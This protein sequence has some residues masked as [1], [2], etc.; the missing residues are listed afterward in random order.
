MAARDERPVVI[1]GAG[2]AG[3]SVAWHLRRL[4]EAAVCLVEREAQPGA[5]STGRN[6]A[7]LREHM[8]DPRLAPWALRGAQALR[9]GGLCA[10]RRSGGLLV[11]RGREAVG[12]YHRQARGE[13]RFAA[14]D[15]VV[16]VAGLLAAYLRGARLH[17]GVT[18]RALE[19]EAGGWRVHAD[20]ATLLARAVVNA[21]GPW[22]GELFGLPLTP[23]N[24]HLF[25][26]APDPEID[27]TGP[28]VW[29]LEGG[30]YFRPESGGWLL[31]A[32]DEAAAA[33]GAYAEREE[34]L[35][36]LGAKLARH[37][38]GLGDLRVVRRWVGQR[39]FAPDGLPVLGADP[40][41]PG[42]FHA[43]GLGGH[44]ITWAHAVGEDVAREVLGARVI[45]DFARVDRLL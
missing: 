17:T 44:G 22:A 43:A 27:R 40:R 20:G 35:L 28:F 23:R 13:A 45:P 3:A 33:P 25:V 9:E 8:E 18:V 41:R 21:A 32:C 10:F 14:G 37:Q 39:T 29:D 4:G 11:G 42:L 2:I 24:R 31:C 38:P 5:H 34:V 36:D 1:V 6:A 16:D 30:Y 7:M 19:P 12:R 26:S 15:G